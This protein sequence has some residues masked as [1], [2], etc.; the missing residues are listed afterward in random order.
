MQACAPNNVNHNEEFL[1]EKMLGFK[2]RGVER[3]SGRAKGSQEYHTYIQAHT[4]T[5]QG[6]SVQDYL[7]RLEQMNHG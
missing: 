5:T 4:N 3:E 6:L 2:V 1:A 7:P